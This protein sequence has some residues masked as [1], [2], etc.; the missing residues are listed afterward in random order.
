MRGWF[1]NT[2]ASIGGFDFFISYAHDDAREYGLSLAD[3]LANLDFTCFIDRS[4]LPPG[5]K[6]SASLQSA[7]RRSRTLILVDTTGARQSKYV[8]LEVELFLE[9][10][11]KIVPIGFGNDLPQHWPELAGIVHLDEAVAALGAGKPTDTVLGGIKNSYQFTRRKVIRRRLL[12]VLTTVFFVLSVALVWQGWR[13]YEEAQRTREAVIISGAVASPDP[14]TSALLLTELSPDRMPRDAVVVGHEIAKRGF[15]ERVLLGPKAPIDRVT[16]GNNGTI[17]AVASGRAYLWLNGY[18]ERPHE[19]GLAGV[20][21]IAFGPNGTRAIA[22]G[23]Q[24]VVIANGDEVLEL[25]PVDLDEGSV[26]TVAFSSDGKLLIASGSSTGGQRV[27][28]GWVRVW[29]LLSDKT[30]PLVFPDH[31]GRISCADLSPN[32]ELL[33]TSGVFG[34]VKLWRLDSPSRPITVFEHGTCAKFSPQGSKIAIAFNGGEV[35][36]HPIDTEGPIVTVGRLGRHNDGVAYLS[37][38]ADGQWLVTGSYDQTARV[39]NLVDPDRPTR[40]VEHD[41]FVKY[42]EFDPKGTWVLSRTIDEV[43]LFHRQDRLS[44]KLLRGPRVS[45]VHFGLDGRGIVSG[46]QDG[47]VRV[48]PL[49]ALPIFERQVVHK[50]AITDLRFN[51]AGDQVLSSSRDGTLTVWRVDPRL[52][53]ILTVDHGAPINAA[54]FSPNGLQIASAGTD[55]DIRLWGLQGGEPVV[56]AACDKA[57]MDLEFSPNGKVAVASCLHGP[58]A[59]LSIDSRRL[60]R[61]FGTQRFDRIEID[62]KGKFVALG[63]LKGKFVL[64]SLENGQANFTE[65]MDWLVTDIDFHPDGS[66]VAVAAGS[67]LYYWT[68]DGS[69]EGKWSQHTDTIWDLEFSANGDLIATASDDGTVR[70]WSLN[71]AAP[72]IVLRGHKAAVLQVSFSPNG[73]RVASASSDGSSRIWSVD[74]IGRSFVLGGSGRMVRSAFAPDGRHV[75]AGSSDGSLYKWLVD[76]NDLLELLRTNIKACLTPTERIRHLGEGLEDALSRYVACEQQAG[77]SGELPPEVIPN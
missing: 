16:V 39:W 53:V 21:D 35:E 9:F 38:S 69:L 54:R 6:L 13:V 49:S 64:A 20:M 41:A 22:I 59:L 72:P 33:A 50:E 73:D 30:T 5:E 47:S 8:K 51:P 37:F 17:G 12:S 24:G 28:A 45:E 1:E 2:K 68:V 77:R 15:P 40:V 32:N 3:S 23:G 67:N 11:R 46:G 56:I 27:E 70:I 29:R 43:R 75:V 62:P 4:E 74:G 60:I 55:G 52:E 19:L 58:P 44:E 25:L 36:I 14:L 76:W 66:R 7:L 42:V 61:R 18:S 31:V 10:D 26:D 48:W 34:P 63:S 57:V 71:G 65:Q